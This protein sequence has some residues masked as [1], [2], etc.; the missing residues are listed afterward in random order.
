MLTSERITSARAPATAELG[1]SAPLCIRPLPVTPLLVYHVYMVGESTVPRRPRWSPPRTDRA[2]LAA[3]NVR[4]RPAAGAPAVTPTPTTGRHAQ[5]PSHSAPP[6]IHRAAR[7]PSPPPRC[8]RS[9][10]TRPIQPGPARSAPPR[11]ICPAT[12][13][14]P[15]RTRSTP[16]APDPPRRAR[17]SPPHP[18]HPGHARYTPATRDPF[19]PRPARADHVRST[20]TTRPHGRAR[21]TSVRTE[22]VPPRVGAAGRG[23]TAPPGSTE[24]VRRCK[25]FPSAMSTRAHRRRAVSPASE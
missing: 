8:T 14:P 19:R 5:P 4:S 21:Q 17:S 20:L 15:R 12:P 23:R 3:S 11:P 10:P 16:A 7:D 22:R 25:P 24:V 18:I 9:S 6:P 1:R 13:D 2:G